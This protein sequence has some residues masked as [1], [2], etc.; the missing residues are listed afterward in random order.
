[1]QHEIDINDFFEQLSIPVYGPYLP[2]IEYSYE[3][4]SVR[5][6]NAYA[7]MRASFIMNKID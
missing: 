2:E 6:F 5:N 3:L 1:M 4:P 7:S